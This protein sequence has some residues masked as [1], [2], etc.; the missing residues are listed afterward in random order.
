MLC[1]LCACWL[2]KRTTSVIHI[3][4]RFDKA[5]GSSNNL[6]MQSNL[7]HLLQNWKEFV[8]F[9]FYPFQLV[10][11]DNV[12]K[13][14]IERLQ[15][16]LQTKYGVAPV[17]FVGTLEKA[18]NAALYPDSMENV[19]LAFD[20]WFVSPVTHSSSVHCWSIF[21]TTKVSSAIFSVRRSSAKNWWSIIFRRTSLSGLGT[22]LWRITKPGSSKWTGRVELLF[23]LVRLRKWWHEIVPDLPL[24]D[25]HPAH[26][27]MLI[28][29]MQHAS[30]EREVFSPFEYHAQ[31]LQRGHLLTKTP[32][33]STLD[34]VLEILRTFRQAWHGHQQ[35]LVPFDVCQST[36][37]C[38]DCLIEITRYLSLNDA[39]N[40]F[41]LSIL[42][43]LRQTHSKVHLNN[44]SNRFLELIP[45][46]VEPRQIASLHI[47]EE[48]LQSERRALTI[49]TFDQLVSL[50][51]VTRQ[52]T[53]E[54]GY[55]LPPLPNL[56][57]FSLCFDG[58]ITSSLF[59][60]LQMLSF[61]S[62][63][64]LH[65][66]CTDLRCYDFRSG[67]QQDGCSKNTTITSF[68][69]DSAYYPAHRDRNFY[70]R[71]RERKPW[72]FVELAIKFIESLVNVQRVRFLTTAIQIE[73][74]LQVH[75]WRNLINQCVR[76]NRV[77][78]QLVDDGDFTQKA[79]QIEQ[80]LR[81]IRPEMIFRITGA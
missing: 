74:Y 17:F 54:G 57:R 10:P 49:R 29:M 47:T 4:D 42:P 53:Y 65:I 28:G 79:H 58:V 44:P 52:S 11:E 63:S 25:P 51:V 45:Q 1:K 9:L 76:L 71:N 66:R 69:L 20:W 38:P 33:V 24:P 26:C 40:A 8:Q 67:T 78:I 73:P 2:P 31:V 43:L 6:P 27:A 12:P 13:Q 50:I 60:K 32:T 72:G 18:M 77:I 30:G 62:I 81:R 23:F 55:P 3:D 7:G 48:L 5:N 70:R 68:I 34:V 21:T 75:L 80:E 37:I 56:R 19:R 16:D 14:L 15:V 61:Q 35:F 36:G 39:I 41:S 22:S 46:H 64:C 59:L